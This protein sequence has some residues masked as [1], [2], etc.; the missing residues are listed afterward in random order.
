MKPVPSC[1]EGQVCLVDGSC[2]K[3]QV[4]RN[5][6]VFRAP[7][8]APIV[9]PRPH[10]FPPREEHILFIHTPRGV[11]GPEPIVVPP[12]HQKN[13]VYVLNKRPKVDP[14]LLE[15]PAGEQHPPEIYFVNYGE[16]ENPQ[17]PLGIDLLSALSYAK[18][19]HTKVIGG[20]SGEGK[21]A[22][23]RPYRVPGVARPH[24]LYTYP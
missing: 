15:V 17:L 19:N 4:K 6:Y 18:E 13:V 21:R 12:P 23:P 10:V 1:G 14:T 20:T 24:G 5:L 16:G 9:G 3:P 7:D 8:L 2:V 22:T 11:L